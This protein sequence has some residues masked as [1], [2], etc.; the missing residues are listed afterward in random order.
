MNRNTKIIIFV[1]EFFGAW[2]TPRGGYGFLARYLIPQALGLPNSNI[3]VCLGRSRNLFK[4]EE[5]ITAEGIKLLKLPKLRYLAA[6]VVNSY[7]LIISIEATVDFLF[8][9]KKRLR[10]KILFWIQDPRPFSDWEEI[11][12]VNLAKEPCYWNDKTYSLV[13]ECYDLNLIQFATQAHF[14]SKKAIEL[15]HLPPHT[16]IPFLPNP[17]SIN[18]LEPQEKSNNIIF[19]GRLDSV[20]RGWL[21]CEIAKQMPQYNFYVMGKSSNDTESN[22]NSIINK[23]RA[24]PNLHFLGHC[25]G[26]K[27]T[28]QLSKAKILINT[29]IHE[30]LPVSFLEAFSHEVSVVSNQNPDGLVERFGIFIGSSHGDGWHDIPK[31]IE[32]VSYLME[33]ES[34]RKLKARQ[35]KN[36]VK[37]VHSFHN[38]RKIFD[39]LTNEF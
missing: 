38:F 29:S 39:E 5:H 23:Y 11:N 24:L 7:D 30:A 9:L 33:H 13:K 16:D 36:Y 37:S 25:E 27:K 10:K 22:N 6:Q 32:A 15:Y 4:S 3:T 12:S 21:F 28:E 26:S 1:N 8:S 2:N 31:F 17:L 19:L 14:L 18:E 35:S 20:K 34:E